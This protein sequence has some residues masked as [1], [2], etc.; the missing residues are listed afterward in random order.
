MR[1]LAILHVIRE[2]DSSR[3]VLKNYVDS[4]L[5]NEYTCKNVRSV[6]IVG[7]EPCR[8]HMPMGIDHRFT[9]LIFPEKN[10]KLSCSNIEAKVL[11]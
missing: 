4:K 2:N 8:L 10:A 1:K 6:I 5:E 3:V 9:T 7:N 11:L